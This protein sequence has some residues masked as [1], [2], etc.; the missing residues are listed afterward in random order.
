ML[1][2]LVLRLEITRRPPESHLCR[3]LVLTLALLYAQIHERCP[4]EHL[5]HC[6]RSVRIQKAK[7]NGMD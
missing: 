6:L 1:V 7:L 3:G 4:L 5:K 2:P